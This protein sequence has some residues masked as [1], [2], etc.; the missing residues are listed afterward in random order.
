M[1]LNQAD[2]KCQFQMSQMAIPLA[3]PLEMTKL[4]KQNRQR[5]PGLHT[6]VGSSKDPAGQ[7]QWQH[8]WTSCGRQGDHRELLG[9]TCC[10]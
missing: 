8:G 9:G 4:Q 2:R 10:F 5:L 7:T 6:G 3:D 1:T